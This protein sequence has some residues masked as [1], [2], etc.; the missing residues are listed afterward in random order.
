MIRPLLGLFVLLPALMAAEEDGPAAAALGFLS[1]L[2]SISAADEIDASKL[3]A[4]FPGTTREKRQVIEAGLRELS[5]DL[6]GAQL[7]VVETRSDTGLAG[8]LVAATFGLNASASEVHPVALIA[9]EETWHPAP[10]PGSFENLGIDY[11]PSLAKPAGRLTTWLKDGAREQTRLLQAGILRSLRESVRETELAHRPA[12]TTPSELLEEFLAAVSRRDLPAVLA[13]VGG[14]ED[15]ID[16]DFPATAAFIA[17]TLNG[18]REFTLPDPTASDHLLALI[19]ETIEADAAIVALGDLDCLKTRRGPDA[20]RVHTFDF[21]RGPSGRWQLDA[22]PDL[23]FPRSAIPSPDHQQRFTKSLLDQHPPRPA[24]DPRTLATRAIE[25]IAKGRPEALL[26]TAARAPDIPL[27]KL[28]ELLRPLTTTRKLN[29]QQVLLDLSPPSDGQS[30][31]LWIAIDLA[32]PE[33]EPDRTGHL[34]LQQQPGGGW[35]LDLQS[36]PS[37]TVAAWLEAQRK[38]DAGHWYRHLGLVSLAPPLDPPELPLPAAEKTARG[39]ATALDELDPVGAFSHAAVAEGDGLHALLDYLGTEFDS[40]CDLEVLQI[41]QEGPWTA[42]SIR[43]RP[44]AKD[45]A[46]TY[47]LHPI[48]ATPAGPRVLAAGILYSEDTRGRRLLNELARKRLGELFPS[49]DLNPLREILR[50][51]EKLAE[52]DRSHP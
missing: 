17:N 10:V 49:S 35:L 29:R 45:Q 12:D 52:E 27:Q 7:Q 39:W 5:Q 22:S 33:I 47:L 36:D 4:L 41:H 13:C 6:A 44:P 19:E 8:V 2:Q 3:T 31:A 26:E 16:E 1:Q 9:R 34:L 20:L 25:A 11:L 37:D 15:P 42:A 50:R 23:L 28:V 32:R 14:A 18:S 21:H 46:A 24:D 48:V 30:A 38:H 51:H 43:H 40:N